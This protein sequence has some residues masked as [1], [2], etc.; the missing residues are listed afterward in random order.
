MC[1]GVELPHRFVSCLLV[2]PLGGVRYELVQ[3]ALLREIVLRT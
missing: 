3:I 1:E 2:N